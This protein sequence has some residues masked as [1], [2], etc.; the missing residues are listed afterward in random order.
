MV[1][2]SFATPVDE[3]ILRDFKIECAKQGFKMNE[4]IEILM[5]GFV[6]GEIQVMKE[7]S[8]KIQQ[9]EKK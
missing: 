4:V 3:E 8:Y 9:D 6:D 1:K 2:R 7:I 5:Q